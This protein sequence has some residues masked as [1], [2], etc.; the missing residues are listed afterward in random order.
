MKKLQI[1]IVGGSIAGCIAAILLGRAG[2]TVTVFERSKSGLVGRGGGVTTS[3]K[4]LDELRHLD[5]LDADFPAVPFHDLKMSIRTVENSYVGHSPLSRAIDMHCVHWSGLW[6]NLRKRVP[7]TCYHRGRSVIKAAQND[8]Q[9]VMLEFEDGAREEFDLVLF[10][11]GYQSLGRKILFPDV[12]IT[13]RGYTV[14]RGVL[15]D[16]AVDDLG[17]LE[18]HPRYSYVDMPGSFVSFV[19]PSRQGSVVPGQRTINWAAYI[20]LPEAQHETFMIDNNGERRNGTIPSGAM[21]PEQDEELKRLMAQQ[22]PTYY[23]DILAKS[24]GNQIQLIYTSTL[25]AYGKGRI[26]LIGDAGMI[27]QPMTGA[28]VFKGYSNVR[29]L[30]AMFERHNDPDIAVTQ[31]SKEQTRVA[32]RMLELGEEMEDAFIWNTIDLAT[33]STEDCEHWWNGAIRVPDEFSY[34]AE[35]ER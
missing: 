22:L 21:R 13:Y 27:V 2:H 8:G 3:R 11:D 14:W 20:P 28:G 33:T 6:E 18:N 9:N 7:D 26:G 12:D 23:A 1:G 5:I 24:T 32:H 16:S 25:P 15:P 29:D 19:V 30:L 35:P 4:V 34:F 10:A 17:P 31:W